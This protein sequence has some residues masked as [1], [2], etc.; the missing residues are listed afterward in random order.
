MGVDMLEF[1]VLRLDDGRIVLAHDQKAAA[2]QAPLSLDEGLDLLAGEAYAAVELDV[3][4]KQPGYER[5]VVAA[6]RARGLVERSLVSSSYRGSLERL[7]ALEPGLR[8]GWSLPRASRDYAAGALLG[9]PARGFLLGMRAWL[10]RAAARALR[11]RRCE[12]LM[13]HAGLVG[14]RLAAAVRA[15]GGLLYVWTVDDAN[16]SS[17]LMALGVDGIITNDPRLFG[18]AFGPSAA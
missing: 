8:R 12:A 4:L 15:E 2:L 17:A 7:G 18:G 5:E 11:E 3:D 9:A 1:D 13:A 6:L 14:P 16:R 10:P